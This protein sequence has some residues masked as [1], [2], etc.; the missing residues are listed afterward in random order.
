MFTISAP[1]DEFSSLL[2]DGGRRRGRRGRDTAGALS[3]TEDGWD[4]G[5]HV[6]Y[7]PKRRRGGH[8]YS[9]YLWLHL[10]KNSFDDDS[11]RNEEERRH[12]ISFHVIGISEWLIDDLYSKCCSGVCC[13]PSPLD[14]APLQNMPF[15]VNASASLMKCLVLG[16]APSSMSLYFTVLL[17][18]SSLWG[19]FFFMLFKTFKNH[20]FQPARFLLNLLFLCSLG[21]AMLQQYFWPNNDK[22]DPMVIK[23]QRKMTIPPSLARVSPSKRSLPSTIASI[24]KSRMQSKNSLREG[25][26]CISRGRAFVDF[27]QKIGNVY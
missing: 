16:N 4:V 20:E 14:F 6:R 15:V 10:D 5:M 25:T 8:L 11:I 17:L 1:L 2:D 7:H 9:R 19:H 27:M 13:Y 22:H 12:L 21:K 18:F 3:T 23:E 26:F 24:R